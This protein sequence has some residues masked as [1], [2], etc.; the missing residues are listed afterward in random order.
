MT[1]LRSLIVCSVR[2]DKNFFAEHNRV[3]VL[4]YWK[5]HIEQ[6]WLRASIAVKMELVVGFNR[7]KAILACHCLPIQRKIV[8]CDNSK[9]FLVEVIFNH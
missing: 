1:K 6:M 2:A 4:R 5:Q 8:D 3:V 9:R 7:Q